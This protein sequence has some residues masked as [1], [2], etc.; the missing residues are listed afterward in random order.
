MPPLI[1]A[2]GVDIPGDRGRSPLMYAVRRVKDAAVRLLLEH[3]AQP[4]YSDID[5][6]TALSYAAAAGYFLGVKRL[7]DKGAETNILDSSNCTPLDYAAYRGHLDII[8]LLF[9]HGAGQPPEALHFAADGGYGAVVQLLLE[10]GVE[11]TSDD[12]KHMMDMQEIQRHPHVVEILRDHW[13]KMVLKER[14]ERL[15]I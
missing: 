8:Q 15:T 5:N 4:N 11:Q 10:H 1:Q 14:P 9:E 12:V 7:L 6:C 3:G 2:Y 13:Q